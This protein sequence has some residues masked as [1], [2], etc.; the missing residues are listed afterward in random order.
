MA[1]ILDSTALDRDQNLHKLS[2][3]KIFHNYILGKAEKWYEVRQRPKNIAFLIFFIN[4]ELKSW[5]FEVNSFFQ[6]KCLFPGRGPRKGLEQKQS[7]H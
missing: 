2:R 7:P 4:G 5:Y 6:L 1:T 3:T